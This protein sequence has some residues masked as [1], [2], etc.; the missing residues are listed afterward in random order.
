MPCKFRTSFLL[1]VM[2]CT[3][4]SVSAHQGI[5]S[6]SADTTF[7]ANGE[8]RTAR[9]YSDGRSVRIQSE[10]TMPAKTGVIFIRL[11]S[12]LAQDLNFQQKVYVEYPYGTAADAQ[13]LRYLRTAEVHSEQ[14]STE[15]FESQECEKVRVTSIYKGQ[16]YKSIEWRSKALHGLVVKSQDGDGKWTAEY[17]NIKVG[18]QPGS[19]F[20]LPAGY[21]RIAFSRDWKSVVQQIELAEGLPEGIEIARKAGLR[22]EEEPQLPDYHSASFF[23]P[24]TGNPVL[25]I[26]VN[27]D[28]FHRVQ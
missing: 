27:I 7:T 15:F 13:F 19:L 6:F 26:G 8:T 9:V 5:Q 4:V 25:N 21:N 28:S 14:L 17:K 3:S 20:E 16:I 18:D 23:D 12:G 2:C 24:A 1:T 11:D 10:A 22:V